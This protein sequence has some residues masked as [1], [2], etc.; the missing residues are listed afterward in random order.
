[1][2]CQIFVTVFQVGVTR[3]N[4]FDSVTYRNN[5]WGVAGY[6]VDGALVPIIVSKVPPLSLPLMPALP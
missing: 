4:L 1:M 3:A 6:F 5:F 2:M